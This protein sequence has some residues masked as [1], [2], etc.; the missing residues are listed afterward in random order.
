ML[1]KN[2]PSKAGQ[3]IILAETVDPHGKPVVKVYGIYPGKWV[4][5]RAR[6]RLR[7]WYADPDGPDVTFSVHKILDKA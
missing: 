2:P 1:S 4:A 7:E 3:Y 5:I 6:D